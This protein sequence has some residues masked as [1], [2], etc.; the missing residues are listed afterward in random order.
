MSLLFLACMQLNAFAINI[1]LTTTNNLLSLARVDILN[2]KCITDG[3]NINGKTISS[4]TTFANHIGTYICEEGS[5][6]SFRYTDQ[7]VLDSNGNP[8]TISSINLN[9]PASELPSCDEFSQPTDG[10]NYAITQTCTLGSNGI[11]LNHIINYKAGTNVH[12]AATFNNDSGSNLEFVQANPQQQNYYGGTSL[13]SSIATGESATFSFYPYPTSA[14][15]ALPNLKQTTISYK[16][17]GTDKECTFNI[18]WDSQHCTVD[19]TSTQDDANTDYICSSV[20]QDPLTGANG[21]CN[22]DLTVTSTINPPSATINPTF[23][24]TITDSSTPLNQIEVSPTPS[25]NN[26]FTCGSGSENCP[27]NVLPAGAT[28]FGYTTNNGTTA[29]LSYGLLQNFDQQDQF[30]CRYQFVHDADGCSSSAEPIGTEVI[31]QLTCAVNDTKSCTPTYTI[32][33]TEHSRNINVNFI[34]NIVPSDAQ[35]GNLVLDTGSIVPNT[36]GV[37]SEFPKIVEPISDINNPPGIAYIQSATNQTVGSLN[38][39]LNSV[40]SNNSYCN[41]Q[42][43]WLYNPNDGG[44]TCSVTATPVNPGATQLVCNVSNPIV[45]GQDCTVNLYASLGSEIIPSTFNVTV[46]NN[47]YDDISAGSMV[48]ANNG[49]NYSPN[50]SSSPVYNGDS[51]SFMYY[52][53]ANSQSIANQITYQMNTLGGICQYIYGWGIDPTTGQQ[54]TCYAYGKQTSSKANLFL[55]CSASAAR[56]GPS[57]NIILG[58]GMP[59]Q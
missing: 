18:V 40:N 30:F 26:Y 5:S 20:V 31:R 28:T 2:P 48:P 16:V 42:M 23:N 12:V 35:P 29:T 22:V 34:N 25:T 53:P 59:G 14:T 19:D 6:L 15:P 45:E 8:I 24:N 50:P 3:G 51:F 36:P 27:P 49:L 7:G 46:N 17:Q 38:Y 37:Y 43:S 1:N 57:C 52:V 9:T 41:V 4:N 13:P 55:N 21:I 10:P 39:Y 33:L 58:F 56:V 11:N 44:A 54:E 32:G 47:I